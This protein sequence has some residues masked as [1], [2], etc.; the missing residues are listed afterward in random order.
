MVSCDLE[1]SIKNRLEDVRAFIVDNSDMIH[2][3]C[4][5]RPLT[6]PVKHTVQQLTSQET[7]TVFGEK[8][9]D[10]DKTVGESRF[11]FLIN[12]REKHTYI[13]PSHKC[14]QSVDTCEVV[15]CDATTGF[16]QTIPSGHR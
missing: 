3:P 7:D 14:M 9:A 16:V 15:V 12:K 8:Y 10:R 4:H 5:F 2:D 6:C 1:T 11:I 13:R